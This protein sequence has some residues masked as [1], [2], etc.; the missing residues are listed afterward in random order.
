MD[1]LHRFPGAWPYLIAIFLNAFVDLGHKIIIQNTVFKIYD[2]STQVVL[3]A[4]V[5][6]LMLLP[7]ILLFSPSGYVSDTFAK[8]RVMRLSAWAA[9]G[10]T[11]LITWSYYAGWFGLAF[12]MTL[13]LAIQ[14]TFYSP[15]KYG[16]IK[17][18]F[19]K[20]R[21]AE[22]NGL[23]QA[24]SIVAILGGTF[25]FTALF[26]SLLSTEAQTA[27]QMLLDIAPLGWLLVVNSLIE[28]VLL[29]RLPVSEAPAS[30]R[31]FSWPAYIRGQA[32]IANLQVLKTQPVIRLS[33]IGL[34]TFWS[35]GQV[36]LAAFPSYAKESLGVTNALVIQ[37]I[38]AASGIGIALGS[39]LASKLSLNRIETGLV[40]LGALGI[41]VGLGG[42]LLLDSATTHALNF[43]FIGIMGGLFIVPLNAL[44]QFYAP[45]EE[46]GTVLAASNWIQNIAMLG[47]LV[48]TAVFALVGVDSYYLLG[49]IAAVAL[50]GG[51]YT[52]GKL[53]QSLVR[54]LLSFFMTRHYKVEVH[55]LQNLP[56][57]GGVLLLGNHISWIDW[58]IVQIASPRP[59]RFVMLKSIYEL[60]FVRWLFKAMG[61]IPIQPG[62]G[63]AQA[64]EQVADLLNQGEVVCLFP[65]G[66]ISRTGQLG[67]FRRGYER[68]CEKANADVVIVPFYLRGLWGSQFSRSSSKLKELRDAPLHRS[69]VVA[70]GKTLPKDTPADVLK[71]RI[72]DQAIRSWQ[73]YMDDL[74]TLADAWIDSVKRRPGELAI[75]DTLGQPLKAAHALAASHAMA[76]RMRKLSPE[77]NVGLL[78]PTSAGGVL[79]NMATL[80][81]GKTVVN[82]NYTASQDALRSALEQSGIQTVYSSKRFISK[83]EQRGLPVADVLAGRQIVYLEDMRQGFTKQELMLTWLA[84]RVLPAWLLRPLLSHSHN[85]DAT[86]TILFS[87][88][89]E[90]AP[91]GVMLSHRNIMA[92]LKQT[93]D[94]LNTQ[95][96]DVVMASLP[97]FHAFGLTVTQFLPLIEGLPL[98]CHADPTDVVGIAKAVTTYR[99]TIMCGTSTFLRLFVRNRKVHPL[100]LDSLR[101]IVAG[102]EKLSTDVRESFTL[103]FNKDIYEGYG[104]TETSPVASVNLPD[105]IDVAYMQ[106]QCGGRKGTVG[107]PLPGTS[108]KIVDPESFEELPTGQEG[109]ILIGGP[110]VMQGYLNNP[111]KTATAI[112]ELD[113]VRWYVTGDK[114]RLDEDGFLTIVD[115]Y[116]RF[117]KIGGEMVSLG[118]V[119]QALSRLIGSSDIEVMAV[120]VPDARKGERIVILYEQPLDSAALEKQMLA[121]G[122]NPLMVPSAWIQVEALPRLGSGKADTVAAKQLAIAASPAES[123]SD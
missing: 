8:V 69:V 16:Y 18:L 6:G 99:A 30:R 81:A 32:A 60:W 65:E 31:P 86:A 76:R 42:L 23:V 120:S 57:Q 24:V 94:V 98:V 87:S 75:A 121:A 101:I 51:A 11:G 91:K 26:E 66:A 33:I 4:L 13:L 27:D 112:R 85:P 56:A 62:A 97:L 108:L 116:S 46:L 123:T 92:N 93:S 73:A 10:I 82:L 43:I 64:L 50:I 77:Q 34:A 122:H 105:A 63:A 5:N 96:D 9:V 102:A 17:T 44:I 61:C 84:I 71:R 68:A 115:R 21:L 52:V 14:A 53:P 111:A 2:G 70:F 15:A 48:L 22:A 72:F 1:K 88:G 49:L 104:A 103:K 80:L 12:A 38:L 54:F 95:D 90:G 28:L 59:V 119:E 114:G 117:A 79:A 55:G 107:M 37:G 118:S 19:G 106:V 3:T 29:Y 41:A 67:E 100:M 74:P 58:A 36:M 89:S 7:F 35:V 113:G 47:F 78:L 45:E 83:L 40:P 39:A 110:Q 109:M 25:V 20:A